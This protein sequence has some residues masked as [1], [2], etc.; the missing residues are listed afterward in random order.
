MKPLE[1]TFSFPPV[2]ASRPRV[3]TRGTFTPKRYADFK[4]ALTLALFKEFGFWAYDIPPVGDKQRSKWL[5]ANRYG[6]RVEAYLDK[7]VGDWDN[8]GKA[9]SDALEQAGIIA[10]D[11]QID[12][13]EVL[14]EVDRKNP[15]LE[16][17]LWK[18]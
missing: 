7:D 3:T 5:K 14:K 9:V 4:K 6:L 10:N 1:F 17:R 8:H 11:K 13:A 2:P 12:Y 16:I 15:R 18:L